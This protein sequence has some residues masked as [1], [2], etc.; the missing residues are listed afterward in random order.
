MY[1][2]ASELTLLIDNTKNEFFTMCTE[3]WLFKI[4]GHILVTISA[5]NFSSHSILTTFISLLFKFIF[6]LNIFNIFLAFIPYP[7]KNVGSES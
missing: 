7:F 2:G 4:R 1:H 6:L 5:M 3:C